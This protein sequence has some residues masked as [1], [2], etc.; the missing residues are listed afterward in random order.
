MVEV[1]EA[2]RGAKI[3]VVVPCWNDGALMLE[4]L[5]S[6]REEA[7]IEVLVVDD[8]SD[9]A[10]TVEILEMVERAGVRVLRQPENRGLSAAR[11]LALET[12]TAPFFFPLD[13]DDLAIPGALNAMRERLEGEPAAGVCFG[14]YVEFGEKE[15]FR[16]VPTELDGFRLAYSN[17]YPVSSLFRREVLVEA[18]GWDVRRNA[19]A[20]HEDWNLWLTLI[21]MGVRGVHLGAGRLSYARRLHGDRLGAAGRSRHTAFYRALVENHPGVFN[22]LGRYRRQSS[23]SPL[24]RVLYPYVYGG[25]SRL[26]VERTVKDALDRHGIWTLTAERRP[27]QRRL[28]EA[29]LAN[30]RGGPGGLRAAA[31]ESRT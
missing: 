13:S 1:S 3:A 15:V 14:D 10:E 29:A 19:I 7:G 30:A 25:R 26:S 21:E 22:D 6:L 23:L 4:T 8:G 16:A 12:T 18:G 2:P 24:R 11:N 31:E 28:L 20:A 9:Q 5:G 17:E 27:E